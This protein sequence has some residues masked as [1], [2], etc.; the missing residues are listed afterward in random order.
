MYMTLEINQEESEKKGKNGL[1]KSFS[2]THS[3]SINNRQ[4]E[5]EPFFSSA[6]FLLL[7]TNLNMKRHLTV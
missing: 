3:Q 1:K 6:P 7:D 2:E 4:I 5:K